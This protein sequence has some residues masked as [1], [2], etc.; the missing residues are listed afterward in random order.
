[1]PLVF[2]HLFKSISLWRK[3]HFALSLTLATSCFARFHMLTA[4]QPGGMSE[5]MLQH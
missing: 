4:L 1:M 3:C 5:G 2:L